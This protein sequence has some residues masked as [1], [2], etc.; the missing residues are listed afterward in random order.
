MFDK[1]KFLRHENVK[2]YGMIFLGTFIMSIGFVVFISPLKLA[3]GGVYGIAIILHHLFQFPIGWSGLALD[4]PLLLMGTLWLGPKFGAKTLAGILS[5][6]GFITFWE[7][8]YG[9]APLVAGDSS[10]FILALGGG[11]FIGLGLGIVFRTRATSGGSD[12]I[13]MIIC[14]YFR[15]LP[16]GTALIIV[17]SI[18]VLGTLPAFKDW[19]IPLYSWL[20]I[21]VSGIVIDKVIAGFSS[22]KAVIIISEH[23][24]EIRQKIIDN[25]QRG[26]TCLHGEGMYSHKEKKIIY[27]VLSRKQ[28]SQLIYLVHEID[29]NAFLSVQ[30]SSVTLGEGFESLKEKAGKG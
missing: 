2:N 17:D 16:L 1:I 20:V 11:V 9:Y 25:L 23:Y 27:T 14:K 26:C 12:I 30:D 19:S 21:Y 3:P 13:A 18:I 6:S 28:L 5:L 4:L 15:H 29:A 22:A 8:I 10:H 24:D 7:H